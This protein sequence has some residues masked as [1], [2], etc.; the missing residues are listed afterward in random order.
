[1]FTTSV[2]LTGAVHDAVGLTK[3]ALVRSRFFAHLQTDGAPQAVWFRRP[4]I[5]FAFI[6]SVVLGGP[7]N[8][9]VSL[10]RQALDRSLM[11]A[12]HDDQIWRE[13]RQVFLEHNATAQTDV[14]EVPTD[15]VLH[16]LEDV[17]RPSFHCFC[18]CPP[19]SSA[20]AWAHRSVEHAAIREAFGRSGVGQVQP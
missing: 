16:F 13:L 4:P 8:R 20:V 12:Q 1:M 19:R 18:G 6:T 9:A 2:E 3:L 15:S 14:E 7:A 5:P 11:F 17:S 10:A